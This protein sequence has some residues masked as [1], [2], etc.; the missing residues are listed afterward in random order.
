MAAPIDFYFDFVSPYGFFA[1]RQIEE[2]AA[3]YQRPVVWR[4]FLMADARAEM[5]IPGLMDVPL[6]GAYSRHDVARIARLM[7]LDLQ[8]GKLAHGAA[9]AAAL[10]YVLNDRDPSLT[11][12][13]VPA[14]FDAVWLHGQDLG[15]PDTVA[16]LAAACG[17]DRAMVRADLGSDLVKQRLKNEVAAALARGVFGSPTVAVDGELFW[18]WD[19]L[20]MAEAWLSSG[21]W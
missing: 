13:F 7:R 14:A 11:G 17:A 4:P 20:A 18:G 15:D 9:P 1:S 6:K 16:D 5:G 12:A 8:P 3:R 19:R 21:G 2:I 10:Y